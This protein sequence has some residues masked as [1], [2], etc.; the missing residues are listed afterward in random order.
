MKNDKENVA[1][2]EE[3]SQIKHHK[4]TTTVTY[5]LFVFWNK[6]TDIG[7][8]PKFNSISKR[9]IMLGLQ[10]RKRNNIEKISVEPES[11]ASVA[12]YLPTLSYL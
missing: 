10:K 3:E 2:A 6:N 5:R 1:S 12:L 7:H 4:R 9:A 11:F 8:L